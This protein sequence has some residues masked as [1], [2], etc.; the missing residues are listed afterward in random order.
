MLIPLT[1][2]IYFFKLL[3]LVLKRIMTIRSEREG[4]GAYIVK[5]TVGGKHNCHKT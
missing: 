5:D 4:C 3:C 2:E 1:L